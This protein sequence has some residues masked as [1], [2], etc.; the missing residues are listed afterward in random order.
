MTW[1]Q[2]ITYVLMA[3]LAGTVAVGVPTLA[4]LPGTWE[5]V[6]GGGV[7]IAFSV[8]S[9]HLYAQIVRRRAEGGDAKAMLK[10]GAWSKSTGDD[11]EAERWVRAAAE[12]GYAPAMLRLSEQLAESGRSEEAEHWLRQSEY[13]PPED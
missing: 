2:R 11:E 13:K 8:V 4:R 6:W 5:T 10:L 3:V 9:A 7:S 12:V 1:G